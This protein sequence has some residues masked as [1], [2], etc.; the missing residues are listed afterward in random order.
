MLIINAHNVITATPDAFDRAASPRLHVDAFRDVIDRLSQRFRW[1][2]IGEVIEHDAPDFRAAALT[3]DDGHRG[4]LTNALPILAERGIPAAVFIVTGA[5][6]GRA[7]LHFDELE[8]AFRLAGAE[9]EALKRAKSALKVMPEASRRGEHERLLRRC[10]VTAADC[11][12]AADEDER[13]ATVDSDDLATLRAGGWT[14]G[15][16]TRTHRAVSTLDDAE[17]HGEIA[18]SRD[19]LRALG[20]DATAFAYPYGA[21]HH[22]GASAPKVVREA[23]YECALTMI[24]GGNTPKPDPFA[25]RRVDVRDVIAYL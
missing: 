25:L 9:P 13:Y 10:G 3:F 5:V 11:R 20:I 1:V 23:G 22:I 8:I 6:T 12:D 16:H 19:D 4:I 18:G 21:A 14:I 24:A 15:S 17:L 2:T 7:P